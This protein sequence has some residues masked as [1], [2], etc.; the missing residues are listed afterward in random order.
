MDIKDI[1]PIKPVS[2]SGNSHSKQ[3]VQFS[4]GLPIKIF[5]S[6][7]EASEETK[8]PK[9]NIYSCAKINAK[10]NDFTRKSGGFRWVYLEDIN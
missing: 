1:K 6:I 8:I 10:T 9:V 7:K 5:M 2:D 3:V 4:C